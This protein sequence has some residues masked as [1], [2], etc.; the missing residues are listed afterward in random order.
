MTIT[1]DHLLHYSIPP[2]SQHYGPRECA[3]YALTLGLGQDPL[4]EGALP[5]VGGRDEVVPFP[6]LPLVLGHPGFWMAHP[7]TGIDA[8]QVVHGEQAIE[9]LQPLPA[10]GTVIGRTRVTGLVDKGHNH[11]ALLYSE[12]ELSTESGVLLARMRAT[13]VLRGDGGFGAS[14]IQP[15][16]PEPVPQ[17]PPDCLVTLQTRPEQAL[18]YRWT[19][20][21]NPLHC[22]PAAA[23]QAGYDRPILH[24]LC[25][26]GMAARAVLQA[27]LDW[28]ASRLHLMRGRFTRPVVPGDT[29]QVRLWRQGHFQVVRQNDGKAVLDH[30]RFG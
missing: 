28:D 17:T 13:I 25:V 10:S 29:L 30:G 7:D 5:Y 2:A 9:I 20:D 27:A 14:T 21:D 3:L 19:G 16:T 11:G 1:P 24:G 26:F 18:Y 6:T 15:P 12:R 22:N 23:R 8:P 4:D